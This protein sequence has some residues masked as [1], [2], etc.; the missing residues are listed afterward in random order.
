MVAVATPRGQWPHWDRSWFCLKTIAREPGTWSGTAPQVRRSQRL[1]GGGSASGRFWGHRLERLAELV[2]AVCG[3]GLSVAFLTPCGRLTQDT[4]EGHRLEWG[5]VPEPPPAGGTAP[6]CPGRTLGRAR[7]PDTL[8]HV[9]TAVGLLWAESAKPPHSS[10]SPGSHGERDKHCLDATVEVLFSEGSRS[11]SMFS[12]ADPGLSC[13]LGSLM[14]AR[15]HRHA[16]QHT[17]GHPHRHALQWSARSPSVLLLLHQVGTALAPGCRPAMTL[18]GLQ[19]RLPCASVCGCGACAQAGRPQT[20]AA[21]GWP[22]MALPVPGHRPLLLRGLWSQRPRL[23]SKAAPGGWLQGGQGGG[24]CSESRC[25]G[26]RARC[27]LLHIL[28][29]VLDA[30]PVPPAWNC[31][32]G[33]RSRRVQP[34]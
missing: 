6:S 22:G 23:G 7:G 24:G 5:S 27:Q 13:G 32:C 21:A 25:M 19:L 1:W 34:G 28:L 20:W 9:C 8:S 33:R 3:V 14:C 10:E 15:T 16:P 4:V 18:P 29:P 31:P 26:R 12:K 30:Q 2:G 11:L 17:P